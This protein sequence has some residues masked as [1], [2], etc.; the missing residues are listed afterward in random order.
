MRETG[1]PG[2]AE[3]VPSVLMGRVKNL[4]SNPGGVR[5]RGVGDELPNIGKEDGPLFRNGMKPF[6][7]LML[8]LRAPQLHLQVHPKLT[9]I[10]T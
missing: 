2:A 3:K 4:S 8:L 10:P 9:P 1:P 7:S 5:S 6:A